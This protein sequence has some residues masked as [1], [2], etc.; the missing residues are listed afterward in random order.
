[1]EVKPGQQILIVVDDHARSLRIAQQLAEVCD[2]EGA[3]VV[4]SFM[5]PRTHNGQEPPRS[6][7]EAMQVTDTVVV[8]C[9]GFGVEHTNAGKSAR[10][11]GIK[12]V[13]CQPERHFNKEISLDDLK[14]IKERSDN[15]AGIVSGS[16]TARVTTPDGTELS[17]SIKGRPGLPLYP[18]SG[19]PIIVVPEYAEVAVAPVEG[20]TEGVLVS[21]FGV[22]GWNLPL[23]EPLRLT[24]EGGRVADVA[25]DRDY[26]T[27]FRKLLEADENATNCA[28]ELGFGTSHTIYRHL[29]L[30]GSL[31]GTIH[32]AVGRNNDIGGET[33][34][35]VHH[36]LIISQPTVWLDDR[37]VVADGELKV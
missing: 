24:I 8:V 23:K 29:M 33:Y 34:S 20:S 4:V 18:L 5:A 25:G 30:S 28:A 26:V 14:K 11:K 27:R 6:I 32:I 17:M 37:C 22:R 13:T 21:D 1:M 12:F 9:D 36:D 16:D 3:E 2:S 15:L 35:Q 19:A 31:T 7:A 10:E